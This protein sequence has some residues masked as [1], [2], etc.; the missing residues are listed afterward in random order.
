MYTVFQ[1]GKVKVLKGGYAEILY[2]AG[3]MI[4]VKYLMCFTLW[5]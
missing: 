3:S 2:V 1:T 4:N 5:I